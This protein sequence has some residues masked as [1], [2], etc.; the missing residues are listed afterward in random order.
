LC[1]PVS[2]DETSGM[3]AQPEAYDHVVI[4]AGSAGCVVAARLSEDPSVSVAVIEAGPPSVGRLFEIPALYTLQYKTS[5]DWDFLT[6]PEPG[7]ARRRAYLPRGRGVGGTGAMNS[8]LY[9][10]GNPSDYDGWRDLGAEGRGYEDVLPWFRYSED[11]ERG[12][13]RYHGV[14]GPLTVSDGRSVHPLLEAWVAAAVEAGHP[15]TDDFNGERQEGVGIYQVT[16]RDGLRCS[17]AVAFLRPAQERPN[18]TVLS[19]TLVRRIVFDGARAIGVEV[20]CDGAVRTI[21]VRGDVVLSAG[22]YQSPQVL[23]L[24][25]V[26]PA[27]E[28]RAAGVEPVVDL[29]EVGRNLQ[30][31]AGLLVSYRSATPQLLGPDTSAQEARLRRDGDGPMTWNEAGAFLRSSYAGEVQDLQFHAALGRF[32]DE[33]LAPATHDAISFGPY[34]ARPASRGTVT[35]RNALPQAKPRITH[36]FLVEEEDRRI[37]RDG[38]RMALEIARRP[39][40]REHL[41]DLDAAIA[42]GTAPAS[43]R[44]ADLDAFM[45]DTVFS[46]FHPCGTCAIGTVVDPELRVRGVEGVRVADASVMPRLITGNTNAPTMM[47]GERAAAFVAGREPAAAPAGAAS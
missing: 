4:G 41:P 19:S 24:S 15:E 44:D 2:G 23:L 20:E 40:L 43:D 14:G 9:V 6:E 13:S 34:V 11:N 29:P 46:F 16:Q 10:R 38:L 37:L 33:G 35:L 30:D 18:L 36:N 26:G 27:D 7:L 32:K 22:A 17:S 42:D 31:H 28:L 45:R 12:E 39:A 25:G 47:I 21:E 1:A 8:M 5:H 3:N